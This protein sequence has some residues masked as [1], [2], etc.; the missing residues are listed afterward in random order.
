MTGL[1]LNL[2]EFL[3]DPKTGECYSEGTAGASCIYDMLARFS[4]STQVSFSCAGKG[5]GTT[6]PL[7]TSSS[8]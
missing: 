5:V 1:R 2:P 8:H 3:I 4:M 6:H 7:P